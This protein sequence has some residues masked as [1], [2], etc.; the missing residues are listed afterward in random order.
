LLNQRF[1]S[2]RTAARKS[3]VVLPVIHTNRTPS[4]KINSEIENIFDLAH[5][6]FNEDPEVKLKI[7]NLM[8]N[9]VDIKNV[10]NQKTKSRGK[11]SSAP[12][13]MVG[14]TGDLN[15]KNNNINKPSYLQ[16]SAKYGCNLISKNSANLTNNINSENTRRNVYSSRFTGS[17]LNTE[18]QPVRITHNGTNSIAK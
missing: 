5:H 7:D 16:S 12:V 3:E 14:R 1:Y 15:F 11:L 2:P 13:Q 8:Q 6:Y 9:I 10:L 18:R 4:V 17:K